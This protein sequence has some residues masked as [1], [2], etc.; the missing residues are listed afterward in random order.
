GVGVAGRRAAHGEQGSAPSEAS[1]E[2]LR[3]LGLELA[4]ARRGRSGF[5][6]VPLLV[7]LAPVRLLARQADLALA[8]VDA[9]HLHLDVVADLDDLLGAVD[10]LVGQLRD[11][12]EAFQ[13]GLEL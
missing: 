10:L 12:Q 11:V 9:E 8:P 5:A 13:A 6:L 1:L 3:L 4:T 2:L 7:A